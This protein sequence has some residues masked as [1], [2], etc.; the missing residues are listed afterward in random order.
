MVWESEMT[1]DLRT[2]QLLLYR[3]DACLSRAF[4]AAPA[5]KNKVKR[6]QEESLAQGGVGDMAA[7]IKAEV[8]KARYRSF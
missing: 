3:L 6:W 7:A 4:Q 2:D 5:D 8:I 1:P